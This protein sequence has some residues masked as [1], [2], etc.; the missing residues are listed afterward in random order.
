MVEGKVV[1]EGVLVEEECWVQEYF[2]GLKKG[3]VQ[4]VARATVT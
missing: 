4:L 1:V 2:H 3:L